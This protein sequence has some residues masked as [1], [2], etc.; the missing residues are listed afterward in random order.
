MNINKLILELKNK[1]G[2]GGHMAGVFSDTAIRDIIMMSLEEF[3]RYSSYEVRVPLRYF[4]MDITQS[5][6]SFDSLYNNQ[7][8]VRVNSTVLEEIESVGSAIKYVRLRKLPS[9]SRAG[10]YSSSMSADIH[11]IRESQ[12]EGMNVATP[13]ITFKPPNI[14]VIKNYQ[15]GVSFYHPYQIIYRVTHPKNLSTITKGLE[16]WF[17]QLCRFNIEIVLYNNELKFLNV[18]LGSSRVDMNLD[19]FSSAESNK[20]ELLTILREKAAIDDAYITYID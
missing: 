9:M 14:L 1:I 6:N 17:E 16:H 3:N 12:R 5:K 20:V 15:M 4:Y 7:V 11:Y 19:N 18:D 13:S 2:L 10:V 8:E